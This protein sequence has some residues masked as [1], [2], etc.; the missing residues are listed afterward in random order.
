MIHLRNV[1]CAAASLFVCP[2][3]GADRDATGQ[4]KEKV[5]AGSRDSIVVTDDAI[6]IHKTAPVFDGHNDLPWA[7]RKS[8][9]VIGKIDLRRTSL[10]CI[11]IFP[12]CVQVV[13]VLNSGRC[14]YR[15]PQHRKIM[16][17]HGDS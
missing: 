12:V 5:S 6:R 2:V 8:G 17:L 16:R 14:M 13:L 9:G 4:A 1:L 11:R 7:A 15:F 10:N 3:S